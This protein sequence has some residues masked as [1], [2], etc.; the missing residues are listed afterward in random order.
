MVMGASAMFLTRRR[1]IRLLLM[2]NIPVVI[3]VRTTGRVTTTAHVTILFGRQDRARIRV[4][5][6]PMQGR[7]LRL[8]PMVFL[9][10]TQERKGLLTSAA[11]S[12]FRRF[13]HPTVATR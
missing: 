1:T 13:Q 6:L 8:V 10:T 3:R 4:N 12:P 11:T 5:F 9:A 7:V 2:N